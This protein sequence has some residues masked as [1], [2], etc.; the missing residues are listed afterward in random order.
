MRGAPGCGKSSFLRSIGAENY[1]LGSDQIR[2]VLS[3]AILTPSGD[4]AINSLNDKTW[5]IFHQLIDERMARGET[6][7]L[8]ATHVNPR[9]IGAYEK[10][11][12][13]HLYE[14]A[15]VDFSAVPLDV[16]LRQNK[17]RPEEQR[18]PEVAV[19]AMH[20]KS[21][22]GPRPRFVREWLEW[23]PDGS[24][25]RALEQ[26]LSIPMHDLS[27]YDNV[28]HIGDL[29]GCITD[30]T[31]GSAPLAKMNPNDFYIFVGDVC[32]RGPE[33][34]KALRWVLD[35]HGQPNMAV[36]YGNHEVHLHRWATGQEAVSHEFE[37]NTL[38]QL[39]AAGITQEEVL[40]FV[41]S[42]KD[43]LTYQHRGRNVIVTHAG[44]PCFPRRLP[45]MSSKQMYSGTGFYQDPIDA[46]F[47]QSN[48][49]WIQFHGH[50]NH[51]QL[52]IAAETNSF[53]LE[54]RVE[55]GGEFR[56][57]TLTPHGVETLGVRNTRVRG[58]VTE[59]VDEVE[60][61]DSITVTV[62]RPK[63]SPR[64]APVAKP[65]VQIMATPAELATLRGH[66]MIREK[67]SASKPHIS[68]FNFTR[69]AFYTQTWDEAN[70]TARGLFINNET[71]E[72]VARSFDKFFNIGE[73][74]NT[75]PEEIKDK[76]RYP[77]T[78]YVKENGFLGILGYDSKADELVFASKSSVDGDFAGYFK[79]IMTKQV[80]P[81]KLAGIK[82]YLR[83]KGKSM[84]FEVIDPV[85]DP[86]IIEYDKESVV[87]LGAI[88]RSMKFH[89]EPLEELQAV[90]R[91]FGLQVKEKGL[92]IHNA[93]Q[94]IGW[95][96]ATQHMEYKHH[97]KD[98][99]GFVLEDK[100]GFQTKLKLPFYS[101]WKKMRAI[102]DMVMKARELGRTPEL[103]WVTPENQAFFDWCMGQPIDA[104]KASIIDL[105]KQYQ[106]AK[107][108]E[109]EI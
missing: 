57:A 44:L 13:K 107:T 24:H 55:F 51:A 49:P 50:R 105:R 73:R 38:P 68:A 66:K 36:L 37:D 82:N 71:G 59:E 98:I 46:Q 18:V 52:P 91:N 94:F 5:N 56:I 1:T 40:K 53:N 86:H 93:A 63:S 109:P 23:R 104:L 99:E 64:P 10:S 26:W 29:Q 39:V 58:G 9:D 106:P 33:N 54:G 85:R 48:S 8:D 101:H 102:S 75:S 74:P 27:S 2:N 97:G 88:D 15:V 67:V 47:A 92:V 80:S 11:A 6:L 21:A 90:G 60:K 20:Q 78:A 89:A 45:M 87:L 77:V 95:H 76:M 30:L 69:D 12:E 70:V 3:G 79:D 7:F 61:P 31:T 25:G 14:A 43:V 17:L 42:T 28:H 4:M 32:D 103:K 65:A 83:E 81:Q 72:I 19:A 62:Q 35:H 16:C 100:D 41:K 96:A 22:N 34:D 84:V 108:P